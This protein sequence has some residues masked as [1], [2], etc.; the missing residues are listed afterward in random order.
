MHPACW[1]RRVKGVGGGPDAD[2]GRAELVHVQVQQLAGARAEGSGSSSSPGQAPETTL[3][4]PP[5]FSIWHLFD[6]QPFAFP[7]FALRPSGTATAHTAD[8]DAAH[9]GA[10]PLMTQL[11]CTYI[12]PRGWLDVSPQPPPPPPA[13]RSI[14][15]LLP[16]PWPRPPHALLL[17]LRPCSS[18]RRYRLFEGMPNAAGPPGRI[19][20]VLE[21]AA[22]ASAAR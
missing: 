16:Q 11:T 13:A 20:S 7:V 18:T 19:C 9:H 3:L 21:A 10:P 4:L 12:A 14:S 15:S 8:H 22:P 17:G 1:W 2:G 6:V 5:L